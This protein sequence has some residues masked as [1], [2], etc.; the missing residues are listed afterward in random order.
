MPFHLVL[1]RVRHV[2][3]CLVLAGQVVS[4][5]TRRPVPDRDPQLAASDCTDSRVGRKRV[6]CAVRRGPIAGVLA[7]F[8][9]IILR[10]VII[11]GRAD[12]KG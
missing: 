8:L 12:R 10:R 6:C 1:S 4:L 11:T 3:S 5:H 2:M 9:T 7:V